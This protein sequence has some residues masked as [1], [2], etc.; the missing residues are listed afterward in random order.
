[1]SNTYVKKYDVGQI[2]L[3][4]PYANYIHELPLLSFGD[5][6]HTINLSLVFNYANRGENTFSVF[7][8]Y[9]FNWQKRII[10]DS[11]TQRPTSFVDEYGK[12]TN[13]YNNDGVY[14]FGDDSQRIMRTTARP[15]LPPIPGSDIEMEDGIETFDYTV[16]YPDGSKEVYNQN[17]YLMSMCDKYS[18]NAF[19]TFLHLSNG[20]LSSII[21][22]NNK[23]I[24]FTYSDDSEITITYKVGSESICTTTINA[25][26]NDSSVLV[27]HY[28]GVEYELQLSNMNFT[29]TGSAIENEETVTY[30]KELIAETNSTLSIIDKIGD[31]IV[32]KIS[33]TYPG[34]ASNFVD[35][36]SNLVVITDKNGVKTMV[37]YDINKPKYSF[38]Y[39]DNFDS[40][41]Y[42]NRYLGNISIYQDQKVVAKQTYNDCDCLLY[43]LNGKWT[44]SLT[45]YGNSRGYFLVSGWVNYFAQQFEL[46]LEGKTDPRKIIY[47][48]PEQ[49]TYF[50][51]IYKSESNDISISFG[52][53][54]GTYKT[55]D[56]KIEYLPDYQEGD[57][58]YAHLYKSEDILNYNG[59][60][61]P[62]D[63]RCI[64][65]TKNGQNN[66]LEGAT[67][68]DI[69][70]YKINAKK[71]VNN[72]EAY[73]NNLKEVITGVTGLAVIYNDQAIDI[74]AVKVGKRIT[75]K[76]NKQYIN[77][78]DIDENN[79]I[80]PIISNNFVNGVLV[81]T[82]QFNSKLDVISETSN[83]ITTSYTYNQDGLLT[84]EGIQGLSTKTVTYSTNTNGDMEIQ[85]T[86][87]FNNSTVCTMD[88]KWGAIKTIR[89]PDNTVITNTYDGD[90]STLMN[91][92]FA[93]GDNARKNIFGYAN[94]RV[95]SLSDGT[96]TY[97][98]G[99]SDKGELESVLKNGTGVEHHT[100]S[101]N[102]NDDT[103]TVVSKY[104]TEASPLHTTTHIYDKYGRL[105]RIEGVLENV[106]DIAPVI[107]ASKVEEIPS[108]D[109]RC[110]V[111]S[112][113]ADLLLGETTTNIYST[114]GE[115]TEKIVVDTADTSDTISRET[116][117]Y[118]SIG[119]VKTEH[120]YP[121][122]D[123]FRCLSK[124]IEYEKGENDPTADGTIS[125]FTYATDTIWGIVPPTFMMHKTTNEYEDDFH[126][127]TK[128][129]H[130]IDNA[131][132]DKCFTYDKSRIEEV[133][134]HIFDQQIGIS[135]Y[136]YD[137][138]GRISSITANGAVTTYTYDEYGQLIRED[139]QGLDKTIEYVYNGIGNIESVKTYDYTPKGTE[140]SGT[141]VIKMTK[142]LTVVSVGK[143]TW[144]TV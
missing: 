17:G 132:F 49:W 123:K 15:S 54:T 70:K 63:D 42:L 6:L 26:D 69:I 40:M 88:S 139:N 93:V 102:E 85:V 130:N 25:S 96:L 77:I 118:D 33:Y 3:D 45:N 116:F 38:E 114:K 135:N 12:T 137:N 8:G 95:N 112:T 78:L 119:R 99:Y 140:P 128:K 9:K 4:L 20:R 80:S 129:T 113:S 71:N 83:D 19:L 141:P 58:E 143:D 30:I 46:T 74:S 104:P 142:A 56:F 48:T 11:S 66:W 52:A 111:L 134:E 7:K 57:W 107:D 101:E 124:T 120:Y 127:L 21:Y 79:P 50:A 125:E 37:Q 86:D 23:K 14:T 61:I 67:V 22:N 68:D 39:K 122:S 105:K 29:V 41:F 64:R 138:M 60:Y 136:E 5:I 59:V 90:M 81:S 117:T 62:I 1:M 84:F 133:E 35:G 27:D 13:L 115:L 109:N 18:D 16:E 47:C 72:G 103:D 91:Q 31:E 73:Y 94:G 43:G 53:N 108:S 44:R 82:S 65:Y 87:E 24:I 131:I 55:R 92:S 28:S 110:A 2:K 97:T 121:T 100:Y 76:E 75:D 106:Y 34:Y 51:F 144:R 10:L 126:R 36:G 32:N 89:L 98:F